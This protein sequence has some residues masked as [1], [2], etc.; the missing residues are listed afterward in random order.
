MDD[1]ENVRRHTASEKERRQRQSEMFQQ[2]REL[3]DCERRDKCSILL[4]AINAIH[5]LDYQ[6]D[7]LQAELGQLNLPMSTAAALEQPASAMVGVVP[8]QRFV[9]AVGDAASSPALLQGSLDKA[10][11][12]SVLSSAA[13]D[14]AEPF[15]SSEDTQSDAFN[16]KGEFDEMLV[17]VEL[18][19]AAASIS[20]ISL[21]HMLN[22]VCWAHVDFDG[23]IIRHNQLLSETLGIP[24]LQNKSFFDLLYAD[25]L[26]P[27]LPILT[28]LL[29]RRDPS[30]WECH[31]RIQDASG[32][33]SPVQVLFGVVREEEYQP[34][35]DP[36][37]VD[38]TEPADDQDASSASVDSA[39]A[40]ASPD[41]A[42]PR[43]RA[44][45]DSI[46]NGYAEAGEEMAEDEDT[47]LEDHEPTQP[48]ARNAQGLEM[49]VHP[50][51]AD[52]VPPAAAP[53]VPARWILEV[54]L[55]PHAEAAPEFHSI[56]SPVQECREA[57]VT[58]LRCL[59]A[60]ADLRESQDSS[61]AQGG[62]L[63]AG[64]TLPLPVPV[65]FLRAHRTLQQQQ[66]QQHP[67]PLLVAIANFEDEE[68]QQQPG[69]TANGTGH[70]GDAGAD[71][72]STSPGDE[73]ASDPQRRSSR[74][75]RRP[76][77]PLGDDD[78]MS[79]DEGEDEGDSEPERAV[80]DA[81][82][83]EFEQGEDDMDD[84]DD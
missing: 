43:D 39:T 12:S 80:Q 20:P 79:D 64:G 6:L 14:P 72:I 71:Q 23:H 31:C 42:D 52:N 9:A 18:A 13:R 44:G 21:E 67:H 37:D 33:Y 58:I 36:V 47:D 41:A 76:R 65:H 10:I 26:V 17:A 61:S 50:L 40:G 54:F 48:G 25:D 3:V 49:L 34:P 5:Q 35:A 15:S 77:P 1:D 66:Q 38:P 45:D 27:H 16:A 73:D 75:S 51:A 30:Q 59:R 7:Q 57:R 24:V 4:S 46:Q 82:G 22:D 63:G 78:V 28:G 2:V 83:E 69:G 53:V 19:E 32:T 84:Q 81:D 62:V 29:S 8:H 70:H 68:K 56:D 11:A 60:A 55:A 74:P